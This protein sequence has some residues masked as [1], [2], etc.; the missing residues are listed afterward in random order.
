MFFFVCE[1]N[2]PKNQ[3]KNTKGTKNGH[4]VPPPLSLEIGVREDE[5]SLMNSHDPSDFVDERADSTQKASYKERKDERQ[6]KVHLQL[7]L[8]QFLCVTAI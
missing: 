3:Y 1:I 4:Q 5:D 8:L 2:M 7:P 6:R